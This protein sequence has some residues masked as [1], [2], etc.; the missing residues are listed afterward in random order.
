[1]LGSEFYKELFA[2]E[3]MEL[4]ELA[5][6]HF[7][8]EEWAAGFGKGVMKEKVLSEVSIHDLQKAHLRQ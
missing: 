8:S 1:M 6:A 7:E 4:V 2:Y 3:I 5:G